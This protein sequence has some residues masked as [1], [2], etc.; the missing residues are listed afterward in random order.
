M[1]PLPGMNFHMGGQIVGLD[2]ALIANLRNLQKLI[3]ES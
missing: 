2:E 1:W 3:I